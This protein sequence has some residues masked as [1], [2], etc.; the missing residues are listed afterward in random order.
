MLTE[1]SARLGKDRVIT[2]ANS[3]GIDTRKLQESGMVR[4]PPIRTPVAIGTVVPRTIVISV[5]ETQDSEAPHPSTFCAIDCAAALLSFRTN[6]MG[7][8]WRAVAW[9]YFSERI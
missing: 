5:R 9:R 8:R 1:L 2:A 4:V 3:V 6:Y 7:S